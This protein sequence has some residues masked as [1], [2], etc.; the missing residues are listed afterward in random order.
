MIVIDG[1]GLIVGRVAAF[2]AKKALEGEDVYIVN[3]QDMIFSGNKKDILERFGHRR[4]RGDP[5]HGPFM[6]VRED[7]MVKRVIRG[8]LP[9]RQPRGMEAFRR[10]KCYKGVPEGLRDKKMETVEAANAEKLGTTKHMKV[11]E[12][13]RLFGVK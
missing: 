10:I 2:A 11:G 7:L 5:H 8:M 1:K 12:V 4:A 6:P 13:S 9:H 3:S